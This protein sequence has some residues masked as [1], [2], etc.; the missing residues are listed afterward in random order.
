MVRPLDDVRGGQTV[1]LAL[2]CKI[3]RN[4]PV[5]GMPFEATALRPILVPISTDPEFSKL[6][7]AQAGQES[8]V[9]AGAEADRIARQI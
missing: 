7:E 4:D 9:G 2:A 8:R 3:A 1:N 5:A 6:Q